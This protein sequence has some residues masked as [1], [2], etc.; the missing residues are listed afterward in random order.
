MCKTS[1]ILASKPCSRLCLVQSS[2]SWM[3]PFPHMK[4]MRLSPRSLVVLN[5]QASVSSGII[6]SGPDSLVCMCTCWLRCTS[7]GNLGSGP[8]SLGPWLEEALP[9]AG[10]CMG[11][12]HPRRSI[13]PKPR[14]SVYWQPHRDVQQMK[15]ACW[16]EVCAT[17]VWSTAMAFW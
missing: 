11:I 13:T 12:W 7:S 17:L 8:D 5:Y 3:V 1:K 10:N 16:C 14:V 2:T 4:Q 15:H 9:L 6:G